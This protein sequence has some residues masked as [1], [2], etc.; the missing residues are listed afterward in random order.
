[1]LED[2]KPK[3]G[4]WNF[5]KDKID[6]E[7][8]EIA[9]KFLTLLKYPKLGVFRTDG[10]YCFQARWLFTFASDLEDSQIIKLSE[11]IWENCEVCFEFNGNSEI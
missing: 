1:M 2:W 10:F 4:M 11:F 8:Y 6:E 7:K 5:V 9:Q 3:V